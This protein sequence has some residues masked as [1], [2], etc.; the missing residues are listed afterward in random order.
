MHDVKP[1]NQK[2]TM[3]EFNSWQ[4]Y[5]V[6]AH[7]VM[8]C[9]RYIHDEEVSNFLET[10]WETSNKRIKRIKDGSKLWRAQLGC[11]Y[12]QIFEKH[13]Y[14]YDE[15][16]PY[17]EFRMTPLPDRASEGRSNPKGIPYLYLSTE[18]N[19]ALAEVR[20]SVGSNI[21]LA[22]FKIIRELKVIDCS[23]HSSSSIPFILGGEPSPEGKEEIVWAHIDNA[24]SRPVLPSDLSADYIPTQIISELFKNKG[25]DGLYYK[26]HLGDGLNVVL[27]DLS[28]ASFE[29]S[30]V[31]QTIDV[32][33]EFKENSPTI[34]RKRKTSKKTA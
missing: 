18:K 9:C 12:R 8:N 24:F 27:F 20:P 17:S 1:Q 29:W 19:T 21:S 2:K 23:S 14:V 30:Q 33:Y 5:S 22:I 6:F 13:E 31:H 15:E 3:N 10:L 25:L 11:D 26:S 28:N 32:K 16:V 34:I 7:K 4:S